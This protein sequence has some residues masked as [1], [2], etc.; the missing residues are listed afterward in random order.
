MPIEV[1]EEV[2]VHAVM[3]SMAAKS[4]VSFPHLRGSR[5]SDPFCYCQ[6]KTVVL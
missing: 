2:F 1:L 3:D 5:R 4:L 6:T